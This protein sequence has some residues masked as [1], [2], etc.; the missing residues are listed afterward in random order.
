MMQEMKFLLINLDPLARP[1]LV[2]PPVPS[3]PRSGGCSA[4]HRSPRANSYFLAGHTV[5]HKKILA[6]RTVEYQDNNLKSALYLN[7]AESTKK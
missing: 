4:F 7:Q 5:L 1:H 6:V 3:V 2:V